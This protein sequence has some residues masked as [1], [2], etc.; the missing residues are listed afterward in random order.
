[1]T[2]GLCLLEIGCGSAVYIRPAAAR[3]PELIAV[4]LG[5]PPE[6]AAMAR[7]NLASLHNNIYYFPVDEG[8]S[9][10]SR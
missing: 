8:F 1:M 5:L 9:G 2:L 4:G 10:V 6:V 3:N 7:G